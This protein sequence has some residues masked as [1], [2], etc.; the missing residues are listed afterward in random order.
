MNKSLLLFFLTTKVFASLLELHVEEG[1]GAFCIRFLTEEEGEYTL[2]VDTRRDGVFDGR[3]S[4][5]RGRFLPGQW[6]KICSKGLGSSVYCALLKLEGKKEVKRRFPLIIK[7]PSWYEGD[8]HVHTRHFSWDAVGSL[9]KMVK[10]ALRYGF[11]F[12]AFTDHADPYPDN[13]NLPKK[14]EEA[15][16]SYL[17]YS[18]FIT[19]IP[20]HEAT[21]IEGAHINVLGTSIS[22]YLGKSGWD[23]AEL[24]KKV[25]LEGGVT[26]LN[27]PFKT[28]NSRDG[29]IDWEDVLSTPSITC[30]EDHCR[31]ASS[32]FCHDPETVTRVYKLWN[33]G[34]GV[35]IV[36]TS[37]AHSCWSYDFGREFTRVYASSPSLPA[38]MDAVK[39]GCMYIVYNSEKK[40]E[41]GAPTLEF[42]LERGDERAMIAQTMEAEEVFLYVKVVAAKKDKVKR[43]R[44][45][46]DGKIFFDK[47]T[48]SMIFEYKQRVKAEKQLHWFCI[49]ALTKEGDR[50]LSNPIFL[51]RRG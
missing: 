42:F 41:V 2:F 34:V 37:D 50:I 38:I 3:D 27:H 23:T 31:K 36:G 25:Y 5:W 32:P 1:K 30:I 9:Q 8:F 43:V 12:I 19:V 17:R 35:W 28:L 45:I 48:D 24:I 11:E 6:V 47:Y 4:V 20:G 10:A 51:R 49:D 21:G 29:S 14:W 39:R 13:I 15:K 16:R 46:K 7:G 44:C 33:K 18:D 26:I 22:L 40:G